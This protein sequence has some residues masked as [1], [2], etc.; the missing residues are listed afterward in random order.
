MQVHCVGGQKGGWHR[1]HPRL[2]C[3][4][5]SAPSLLQMK[6][7]QKLFPPSNIRIHQIIFELCVTEE[8]RRK[9]MNKI[10]NFA[11]GFFSLVKG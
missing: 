4:L 2:V 6:F 3:V 8:K 5:F 9:K 10:D 11:L 1:S 7:F